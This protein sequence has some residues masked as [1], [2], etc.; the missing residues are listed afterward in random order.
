MKECQDCEYKGYSPQFCTVHVKHCRKNQGRE[1]KPIPNS[2]K[3]GAKTLAGVGVGMG[4]VVLGSAAVSL[5]GG[6]VV[7]HAI[8]LKLG[9]GA[10]L[11]GG[12]IGF[13]KGLAD[14]KDRTE[15]E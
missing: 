9:A 15:I 5:V 13:Y 3:V 10:G 11:A 4:A 1:R 7:V 14:N 8:L 12:G 6:A 2:V